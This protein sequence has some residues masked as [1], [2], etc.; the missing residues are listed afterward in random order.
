VTVNGSEVARDTSRINGWDQVDP[1]TIELFGVPCNDAVN[2]G[3]GATIVVI[4]VC[5]G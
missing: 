5:V 1:N 4:R 2:G 3:A